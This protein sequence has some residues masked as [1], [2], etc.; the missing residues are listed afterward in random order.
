M[1]DTPVIY[2]FLIQMILDMTMKAMFLHQICPP[3]SQMNV[4][5][6]LIPQPAPEIC[7][8]REIKS[9]TPARYPSVTE[10]SEV[11]NS[12]TELQVEPFPSPPG[13]YD[14]GGGRRGTQQRVH[15]LVCP[16]HLMDLDHAQRVSAS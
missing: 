13:D 6:A 7:I 9:I 3:W 12:H 14:R 11:L 15:L 8:G 16:P 4:T 2:L 1:D 5:N 10:T